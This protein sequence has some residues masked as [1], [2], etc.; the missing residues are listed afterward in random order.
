MTTDSGTE[1]KTVDL[2]DVL[3]AFVEWIKG[4]PISDCRG[5]V[6]HSRRLMCN[7]LMGARLVPLLGRIDEGG[8]A[9]V[10]L[11]ATDADTDVHPR[12]FLEKC[13]GDT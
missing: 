7:C 11:L 9:R 1:L 2:P 4:T 5:L 6:V 10:P 12:E 13:K 3:R 8:R